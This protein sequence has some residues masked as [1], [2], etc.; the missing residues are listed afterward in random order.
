MSV[1]TQ[2][3]GDQQARPAG[4]PLPA[5]RR[6][7]ASAGASAWHMTQRKLRALL[8]QP[9]YLAI[10]LIQPIIWLL[11]FGALFK[12]IVE[13]PG[14][15]GGSYIDFLTPGI[16]VMTALFSSGW[17]GMGMLQDL[18]R[19]ILDRFLV[20]PVR[21][22]PLIA[23]PLIQL[24]IVVVIQSL[25]IVGLGLIVGASFPGGVVGVI[26]L[27]V[28]SVLL[29]AAL[30]GISNGLALLAR[31]EETLIAAVNFIVLPLTFLSSTFMQ[32]NL[33]PVWIQEIA[34]FNPVNWAVQAGR[35][36]LSANVDW[37]LV[38]SRCGYLVA[39]A[40]VCGWFATRAFRSY[41]RSI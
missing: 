8:R 35:S 30:G 27:V 17:N 24:S 10:T 34:R 18:E 29:G 15:D 1:A 22:W 6:G 33:I 38:L 9:W 2:P 39:L 32:Q 31:K 14:F 12:K 11:L 13:I 4:A 28:V 16:V 19:G 41:Q 20:S 25:I 23:G 21:R 7:G 37:G 36:A 40:L 5:G 26:V 3:G